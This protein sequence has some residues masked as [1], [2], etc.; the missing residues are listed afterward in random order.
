MDMY[1]QLLGA[2]MVPFS[3]N[4]RGTYRSEPTYD[5][6]LPE[7]APAN[8]AFL[9]YVNENEQLQSL[10]Q[11]IR[12][13]RVFRNT[14]RVYDVVQIDM[15]T[16]APEQELPAQLGLDISQHGW[17]SLLHFGLHWE[18]ITSLSV[19]QKPLIRLIEAYFRSLLNANGL[20]ARWNDARF[21]LDVV[22][23]ISMFSPGTWEAPGHEQ[24]EIVRLVAITDGQQP[25]PNSL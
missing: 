20:F 18:D 23:A 9:E 22:E 16:N 4:Y 25:L 7:N 11:A 13:A 21:F 6:T 14:G 8:Q 1:Y 15:L 19:P 17:Y 24:F 2:P 5:E 3:L 12:L 10:E